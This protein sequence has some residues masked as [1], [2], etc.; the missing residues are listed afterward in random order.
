M[1][2]V[3]RLVA[4][5]VVFMV[6]AGDC[7]AGEEESGEVSFDCEGTLLIPLA[8]PLQGM[9]ANV[10]AWHSATEFLGSGL[11][12][13]A[14][15]MKLGSSRK[16]RF[17]HMLLMWYISQATAYYSHE[18]A[19]QIHN[20]RDNQHFWVDMGDWDNLV[21]EFKFNR[22]EDVWDLEDL[23]KY[24]W[25]VVKEESG[26]YQE[27]FNSWFIGRNSDL[28]GSTDICNAMSFLHMH[29]SDFW[30][31]LFYGGRE[32][33]WLSYK[34]YLCVDDNDVTG[35]ILDMRDMG[36]TI[37]REDWLVAS[38][39]A[40]FASGQT[41][42]S[43]RSLYRYLMD[44]RESMDNLRFSLSD[45]LTIT[46]PNFYLFSTYRGLYMD[47]EVFLQ[48]LLHRGDGIHFTLGTGLDSFGLN[49]TGPVDWVRVGGKYYPDGRAVDL[50]G[51]ECSP[52]CYLNFDR[53]LRHRGESVGL[54][55]RTPVW[56]RM[57]VRAMVEYSREDMHKQV[58]KY[59]EEGVFF[60]AALGIA[61]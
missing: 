13:A 47:M 27:K 48:G 2:G 41:W 37:S 31:N 38:A 32:V 9:D 52:F 45:R 10:L 4:I 56:K 16:R 34:G 39:L 54:E 44:G 24:D 59:R 22:F 1:S 23:T 58:I 17:G 28:D 26:L 21:P 46:P 33:K 61:L 42:N 29:R 49:Q 43:S 57:F 20:H 3:V 25:H 6:L 60:L 30:Y 55:V 12:Y 11:D 50:V 36:I 8:N 40:L 14:E 35:Y 18:I 53:D 51:F 15:R 7:I 5:G 19:H